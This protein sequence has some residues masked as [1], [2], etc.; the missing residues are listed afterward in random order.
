MMIVAMLNALKIAQHN[1]EVQSLG[2]KEWL[3]RLV[4]AT[5]VWI[6]MDLFYSLS[7]FGLSSWEWY[8]F[9]GVSVLCLLFSQVPETNTH[10]MLSKKRRLNV[11]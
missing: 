2:R 5:R 6:Y 10:P 8:F 7:C 4:L 3:F 1:L 9:G 11:R